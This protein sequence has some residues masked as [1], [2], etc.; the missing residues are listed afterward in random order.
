MRRMRSYVLLVLSSKKW[1]SVKYGF[2][3][4]DKWFLLCGSTQIFFVSRIVKISFGFFSI[5]NVVHTMY[6]HP[7]WYAVCFEGRFHHQSYWLRKFLTLRHSDES[8][9]AILGRAI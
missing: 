7:V 1:A 6:V 9:L 4:R 3:I 5:F 8:K 2:E